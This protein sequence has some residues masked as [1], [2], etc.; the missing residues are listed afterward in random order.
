ML[1][2]AFFV[3]LAQNPPYHPPPG[4][5]R[6]SYIG[7]TFP[8]PGGNAEGEWVQNAAD[9]IEVAPD[10][11]VVAGV[12]WD[13]AGRCVGLYRAG[14]TNK[15][16]FKTEEAIW[17]A[18]WGWGT[19]NQ[20]VSVD[21]DRIWV[22]TISQFLLEYRWTPGE[23][24]SWEYLGYRRLPDYP[25]GLN[26]RD[27]VM[28]TVFNPAKS[29]PSDPNRS[30]YLRIVDRQT[31][32]LL[33]EF[34][35]PQLRDVA[36]ADRDSVFLLLDRTVERMLISS[37][38]RFTLATLDRPG[39]VAVSPRGDL[40]VT[41]NG[42]A[43]RIYV[44]DFP[45]G[46]RRVKSVIGARG[47]LLSGTPG[48]VQPQKFF[49]LVGANFDRHGQLHVAM[50]F[51]PTEDSS[52]SGN[53]FLRTFDHRMRQRYEV[54]S[55]AFVDTFGFDPE[56]DGR[57]VVSRTAVYDLDLNETRIG[58]EAK[59]VGISVDPTSGDSR[60]GGAAT[61]YAR[62]LNGKRFLYVRGQ[63]SGG[64]GIYRY[65][66]PGYLAQ[67]VLSWPRYDAEYWGWFLERDGTVWNSDGPL[68]RVISRFPIVGFDLNGNPRYDFDNPETFPYTDDWDVIRRLDYNAKTDTMIVTGYLKS[69]R[70]DRWGLAGFTMRRY[71]RFRQGPRTIAWTNS[72]LPT[73]GYTGE[74]GPFS[75]ISM[76]TAGDYVFL[77]ML[78]PTQGYGMVHIF[79][80]A[81][82]RYVGTLIPDPVKIGEV[83]WIDMPYGLD[84]VQ[85]SDGE[86]LILREED[87]RAKNLLFRWRDR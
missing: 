47:G 5:Y 49:A 85:T 50:S 19:A 31:G 2:A 70:F 75:P 26:A 33:R 10:G 84:A 45:N 39:S 79:T 56:S 48:E 86:Y 65:Q 24:D 52:P 29:S 55:T 40:V 25:I 81:E 16:G 57:R 34:A 63:Y 82:G 17:D 36:V 66:D 67:H 76:A 7:N 51:Q 3:A 30:R 73:D 74:N 64:Y 12:S 41:E 13:E 60:Q 59:L 32:Q 8:G 22:G 78:F 46:A 20:A 80:K 54:H 61:A 4:R 27:G 28:A 14:R 53:F 77:G 9:E 11:T 23:I 38:K 42:V 83:G 62:T 15:R 72:N 43:Q 37:G 71:D 1:V 68:G 69:D 44:Y 87:Y 21:G 35:H 18:A 6:T 58:K